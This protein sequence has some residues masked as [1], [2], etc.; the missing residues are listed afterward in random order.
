MDQEHEELI[1]QRLWAERNLCFLQIIPFVIR[2]NDENKTLFKFELP[3][4]MS[5]IQ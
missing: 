3:K 2:H 4:A 5:E 1:P